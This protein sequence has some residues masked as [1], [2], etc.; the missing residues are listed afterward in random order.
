MGNERKCR[1]RMGEST[2]EGEL[3]K[4]NEDYSWGKKLWRFAFASYKKPER[5]PTPDREIV[6]MQQR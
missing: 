5:K 2:K 4:K 6:K 1:P 3:I